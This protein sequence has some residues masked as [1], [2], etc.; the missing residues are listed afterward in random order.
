MELALERIRESVAGV[1][2]VLQRE[3]EQRQQVDV[4]GLVTLVLREASVLQRDN[5]APVLE[6]LQST[7]TVLAELAGKP[8][9][10]VQLTAEVRLPAARRVKRTKEFKQD[11][12]G[13]VTGSTETEEEAD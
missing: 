7:T 5:L 10:P 1:Q 3:L 9:A 8:P 2:A 6:Q 4:G 13:H 12:R 11:E